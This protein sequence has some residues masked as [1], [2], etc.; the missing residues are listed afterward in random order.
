MI[1]VNNVTQIGNIKNSVDNRTQSQCK[2]YHKW[3]KYK[4][5]LFGRTVNVYFIIIS[6]INLLRIKILLPLI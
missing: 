6:M 2:N 4:K 1:Y 5:I 3:E